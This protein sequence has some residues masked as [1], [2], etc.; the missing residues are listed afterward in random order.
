MVWGRAK[1]K[2]KNKVNV[3]FFFFLVVVSQPLEFKPA[4]LGSKVDPFLSLAF[5]RCYWG[6]WQPFCQ[7]IAKYSAYSRHLVH[8]VP[9][10]GTFV[11]SCQLLESKIVKNASLYFLKMPCTSSWISRICISP[12]FLAFLFSY[13]SNGAPYN[14][15]MTPIY[16]LQEIYY[17]LPRGW[18]TSFVFFFHLVL[19]LDGMFILLLLPLPPWH[20]S[21]KNRTLWNGTIR[22]VLNRQSSNHQVSKIEKSWT[23]HI[24]LCCHYFF[25][26]LL[27][28]LRP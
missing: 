12:I 22:V 25:I 11:I 16:W 1:E 24:A 20:L 13:W 18:D 27:C 4:Y 10:W 3:D 5:L 17:L 2:Q 28:P 6:W 23:S 8:G 26:Y 7:M 19:P 9:S 21:D 15:W 14:L